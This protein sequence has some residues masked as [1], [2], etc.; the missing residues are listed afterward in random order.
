[1]KDWTEVIIAIADINDAVKCFAMALQK[2]GQ[3]F[4]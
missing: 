1:M 3:F 2:L 4:A